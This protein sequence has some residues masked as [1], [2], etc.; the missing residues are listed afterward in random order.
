VAA[1][2]RQVMVLVTEEQARA[3]EA[4]A[5]ERQLS[6]SALMREAVRDFLA[7]QRK[8]AAAG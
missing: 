8:L 6:I 2:V 5:R 4:L 3:I 1:Y 7:A